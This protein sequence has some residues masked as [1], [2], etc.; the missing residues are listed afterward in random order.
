MIDWLKAVFSVKPI[1]GYADCERA[2]IGD[3]DSYD[4]R[5]K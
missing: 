4:K 5:S 1:S 2:K 3:G